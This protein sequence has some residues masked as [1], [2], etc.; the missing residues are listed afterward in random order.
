AAGSAAG[1][2]IAAI[3]FDTLARQVPRWLQLLGDPGMNGRTAVFAAIMAGLTLAIAGLVPAL[4][5]SS[6]AP[7]AGLAAGGRQATTVR[8]GR[9]A[10][11]LVEVALATVVLC[12]GSIMLRSWIGLNTQ[13]S[14]MDADRVIAVRATPS[15]VNDAARTARFN[16]LV[17]DA[18]QR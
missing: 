6:A 3:S 13:R 16:T 12:A 17:A 11:L 14:G 4:R 2:L 1:W 5:A 15:G 18:V 9:H 8:R 10:L 7:G